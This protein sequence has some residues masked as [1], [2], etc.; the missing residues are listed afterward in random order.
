MGV[1]PFLSGIF[2]GQECALLSISGLSTAQSQTTAPVRVTAAIKRNS[3][4]HRRD[5]S[6]T[7]LWSTSV[8]TSSL[9]HNSQLRARPRVPAATYAHLGLG[10]TD[11]RSRNDA[12]KLTSRK[13]QPLIGIGTCGRRAGRLGWPQRDAGSASQ[14]IDCYRLHVDARH[15]NTS[16]SRSDR[17]ADQIRPRFMSSKFDAALPGTPITYRFHRE[18]DCRV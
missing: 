8:V 14:I 13:S 4:D 17:G 9:L 1:T 11:A 16:K 7:G 3:A 6:K 12:G 18:G 2:L 10:V 15:G 5:R